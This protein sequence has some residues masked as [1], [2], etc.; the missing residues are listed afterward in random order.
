MALV[1]METTKMC[2]RMRRDLVGVISAGFYLFGGDDK[3]SIEATKSLYK[4]VLKDIFE[5]ISDEE[6]EQ[7]YYEQKKEFVKTEAEKNEKEKEVN[8]EKGNWADIETI[9]KDI[10]K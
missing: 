1:A 2:K 6:I 3:V 7:I 10:L 4:M 9:I 8:R 5:S